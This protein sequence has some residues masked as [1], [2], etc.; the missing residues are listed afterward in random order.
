MLAYL[1]HQKQLFLGAIFVR[2]ISKIT[3]KVTIFLNTEIPQLMKQVYLVLGV[4][5]SCIIILFVEDI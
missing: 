1:V 5:M 2:V 3:T 4:S